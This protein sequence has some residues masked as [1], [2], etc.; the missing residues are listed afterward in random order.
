[1]KETIRFYNCSRC[2]CDWTT[3]V[4]LPYWTRERIIETRTSLDNF[5]GDHHC[6]RCTAR[7]ILISLSTNAGKAADD[8][9][10][11]KKLRKLGW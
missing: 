1:M 8:K 3:K 6:P 5:F 11:E 2:G 4:S 9:T 7:D 10:I